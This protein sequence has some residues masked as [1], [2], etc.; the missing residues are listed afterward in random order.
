MHILMSSISKGDDNIL[1]T[2]GVFNDVTMQVKTVP[3]FDVI[4]FALSLR[5]TYFGFFFSVGLHDKS[6]LNSL[7]TFSALEIRFHCPYFIRLICSEAIRKLT[8]DSE[9]SVLQYFPE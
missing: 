1:Y 7:L 3:F 4:S 9:L 2:N 5:Q 6:I 8:T